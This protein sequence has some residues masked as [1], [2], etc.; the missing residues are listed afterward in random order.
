[1]SGKKEAAIK[2]KRDKKDK[3]K[4]KKKEKGRRKKRGTRVGKKSQG[5]W[6]NLKVLLAKN[7]RHQE[8]VS[9]FDA[10]TRSEGRGGDDIPPYSMK[11]D[12]R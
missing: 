8:I 12:E 10:M 11:G 1:M 6:Q 9:K 7:S 4:K 5:D 3:K 2:K